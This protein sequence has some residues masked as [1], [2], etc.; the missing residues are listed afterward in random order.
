[1]TLA[2]VDVCTS[3]PPGNTVCELEWNSPGC[4]ENQNRVGEW[5]E[6]RFFYLTAEV[7]ASKDI[8]RSTQHSKAAV[9][10]IKFKYLYISQVSTT[11]NCV[12]SICTPFKKGCTH[13]TVPLVFLYLGQCDGEK[14]T[15]LPAG[16]FFSER[17]KPSSAWSRSSCKTQ[18]P[19]HLCPDVPFKLI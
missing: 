11:Q 5:L 8:Q 10:I 14:L 18:A 4:H 16:D 17:F 2:V 3:P 9:L 6:S 19:P 7:C 1:M 13:L 12:H 15:D